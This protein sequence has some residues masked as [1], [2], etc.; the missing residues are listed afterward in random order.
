MPLVL[1]KEDKKPVGRYSR[2][3]AWLA[4]LADVPEGLTDE[5]ER[6]IFRRICLLNQTKQGRGCSLVRL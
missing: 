4:S 1:Q 2:E 3:F 5:L 6:Q